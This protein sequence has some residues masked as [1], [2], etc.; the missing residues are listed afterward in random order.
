M[1]CYDPYIVR[2]RRGRKIIDGFLRIYCSIE[3]FWVSVRNMRI[4]EDRC[5][6]RDG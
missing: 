3:E 2:V 5:E 1:E 6:A 4:G